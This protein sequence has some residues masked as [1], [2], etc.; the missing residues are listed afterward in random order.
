[1]FKNIAEMKLNFFKSYEKDSE[2]SLEDFF[3]VFQEKCYELYKI[4]WIQS[5]IL[6]DRFFE[7]Y[8]QYVLDYQWDLLDGWDMD[9][10]TENKPSFDEWLFENGFDGEIYVCFNEFIE[11]EYLDE[12]YMKELLTSNK[13]KDI[14]NL[15]EI[16]QCHMEYNQSLE[17]EYNDKE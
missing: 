4:D 1:M 9:Y 8:Q 5:H 16:Y 7:K 3:K 13:S 14:N 17:E 12:N 10:W 15:F 6:S 2:Y 11:Y